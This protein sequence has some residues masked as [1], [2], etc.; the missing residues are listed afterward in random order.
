[1]DGGYCVPILLHNRNSS[2]GI[3]WR[4]WRVTSACHLAIYFLVDRFSVD[5]NTAVRQKPT[6]QFCKEPEYEAGRR[7]YLDNQSR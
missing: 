1:M 2:S 4:Y 7:F 3:Q 5:E 6:L